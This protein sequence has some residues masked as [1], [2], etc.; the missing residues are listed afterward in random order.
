MSTLGSQSWPTI[1]EL[2]AQERDLVLDRAD[3]GSLHTLGR[4]MS[5][6]A[7][8]ADFPIVIQIRSGG[9]LVYV[10]ALPGSTASNDEWATRKAR[11]AQHF[12]QSSLLVRLVRERDG[13]DINTRHALPPSSSRHRR[14][15]PVA[16]VRRRGHRHGRQSG[17]PAARRSRLRGRA[18]RG[19]PRGAAMPDQPDPNAMPAPRPPRPP[20]PP[21]STRTPPAH[22]STLEAVPADQRAALQVLAQTIAAAAPDAFET[23]S[24]GMPA[25]RY[26]GRALVSYSAFKEHCSLFPVAPR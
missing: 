17:A 19:L 8:D 14:G 12:E 5:K 18:A 25:F 15:I 21:T 2:E 9:R 23:I 6:A 1:D 10:A 13:E 16:C 20:R 4:R 26:H 3:L 7:A 11:L 24:Y 22:R